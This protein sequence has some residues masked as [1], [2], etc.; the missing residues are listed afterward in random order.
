MRISLF[1]NVRTP[2][3]PIGNRKSS[4]GNVHPPKN[5]PRLRHPSLEG[6]FN[7]W[8][9]VSENASP[10]EIQNSLLDIRYSS[11]FLSAVP[12]TSSSDSG[13]ENCSSLFPMVGTI[14]SQSAIGN[15]HSAIP[16]TFPRLQRAPGDLIV[17]FCNFLKLPGLC[18]MRG[19][20]DQSGC[21]S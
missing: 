10:F 5:P 12:L 1:P 17:E 16:S 2:F 21:H 13:C 4:V 8:N 11:P 15:L 14:F 19:G 18:G 3:L 6:I 9:S 20:N 7:V